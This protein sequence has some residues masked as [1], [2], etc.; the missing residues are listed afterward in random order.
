MPIWEYLQTT[1]RNL[2]APLQ[3]LPLRAG[4]VDLTPIVGMALVSALAMLLASGWN[5]GGSWWLPKSIREG[6]PEL[7][8]VGVLPWLFQR[9]PF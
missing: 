7:V 2:I 4:K 1:G 8:R 5:V 9:L 6:I 3:V